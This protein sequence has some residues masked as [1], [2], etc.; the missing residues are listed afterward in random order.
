MN[1]SG[2]RTTP[3]SIVVGFEVNG[4]QFEMS[5]NAKALPQ[6]VPVTNFASISELKPERKKPGPK[7]GMK[8]HATTVD[9]LAQKKV[10]A[11][12]AGPNGE[13]QP[14]QAT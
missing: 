4:E 5:I 6:V 9:K 12:A 11:E 3:T 8:K 10:K 1:I 13:H 14:E 7:P 2:V